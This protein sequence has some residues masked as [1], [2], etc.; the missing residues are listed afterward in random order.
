MKRVIR[1]SMLAAV[2]IAMVSISGCKK[3]DG[4][5][6]GG[7]TAKL[8]P[9]VWIQGKWGVEEHEIFRFTSD[10]VFYVNVSLK[11]IWNANVTGMASV[12]LKETKNTD[13]LYELTVSASA[14]GEKASGY[15]SFRKG[16]G[17]YI[18]AASNETGTPLTESD[19]GRFDRIN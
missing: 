13:S 5:G 10:D 3:D 12:S 8:S 11:T 14:G 16:D 4:G 15:Y 2:M 7:K 1:C 18:D 6:D 17:T 19:Y 9:P